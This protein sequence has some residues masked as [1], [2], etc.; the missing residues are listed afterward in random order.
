[1]LDRLRSV[2]VVRQN[3]SRGRYHVV[4]THDEDSIR[5]RRARA[6]PAPGARTTRVRPRRIRHRDKTDPVAVPCRAAIQPVSKRGAGDGHVSGEFVQAHRQPAPLMAH[7]IDLHDHGRR[8]REAL[9]DAQQRVRHENPV[10]ARRPHQDERHR[11]RDDPAGDEHLLPPDPI[12]QPAR[13]V[14]RER[15]GH[16]EYDD[17]R[18][19]RRAGDEM[20][21]LLG[22][23]REDAALHADHRAHERVD[24]DEQ[25]ELRDVLP[26][27][28][29]DRRTAVENHG[30]RHVRAPAS[31]CPRLNAR[32][33]SISA[34]FGGTSARPR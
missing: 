26:E 31:S 24:D 15:L 17:E 4:P 16:A 32:T 34:G 25:R 9:T 13:G 12:R 28:Q 1:M 23:G 11:Y 21:L 2:H 8:P 29:T 33:R 30:R 27:S 14:V 5:A 7:E 6:S 22:D 3:T 10:P 19:H 18:Q 20:K